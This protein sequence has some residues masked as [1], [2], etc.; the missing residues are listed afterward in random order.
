MEHFST[1]SYDVADFGFRQILQS[2]GSAFKIHFMPLRHYL[3]RQNFK[4]LLKE[5]GFI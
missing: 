2:A 5:T 3:H 1:T 4:I